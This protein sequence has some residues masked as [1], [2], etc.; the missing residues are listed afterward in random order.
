MYGRV[1]RNSLMKD[2]GQETTVLR[3]RYAIR[4][5]WD[6]VVEGNHITLII[7]HFFI[8]LVVTL[9]SFLFFIFTFIY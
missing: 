1:I 2:I 5:R 4:V 7:E 6:G 9:L 8:T 3:C